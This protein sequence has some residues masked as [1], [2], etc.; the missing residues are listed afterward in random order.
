MIHGRDK[1][2]QAH[3][4]L[5]RLFELVGKKWDLVVIESVRT[6]E[7]QKRLLD[8]GKTRTLQSKHLHR[9]SLA[10]DVAPMPVDWR[11]TERF[12]EF[13]EY[14]V[15]EA[16]GLGI[17]LRWGGDWDGDGDYKDQK[18]NDLVHFEVRDD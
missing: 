16:N 6:P 15:D 14:V 9:P 1:L 7:R 5:I 3:S 12:Y 8:E 4:D 11:D 13:G 10:V 2:E 18:F 17:D